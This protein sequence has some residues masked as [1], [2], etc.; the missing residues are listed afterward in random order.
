VNAQEQYYELAY[1]TLSHKGSEF[2]HQHIVDA[3]T[4]QTATDQTKNIA[5]N[6]ALLGL[7]LHLEKHYTGKEVQQAH[8]ALSNIT[9]DYKSFELPISRGAIT[10]TE[11]LQVPAGEKRDQMI[12][13]WCQSVWDAYSHVHADIARLAELIR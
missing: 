9:K 12:D 8:V 13:Q 5:I 4:A 3:F 2:I 6:Y 1:Y 7:Y 11:V 10:V